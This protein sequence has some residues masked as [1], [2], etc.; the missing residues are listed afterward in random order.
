MDDVIRDKSS[1]TCIGSTMGNV[2]CD[3]GHTGRM[4]ILS[5]RIHFSGCSKRHDWH[6]PRTFK[7]RLFRSVRRF[8]AGSFMMLWRFSAVNVINSVPQATQMQFKTLWMMGRKSAEITGVA[9]V[10]WP[11]CPLQISGGEEH[12]EQSTPGVTVPSRGSKTVEI[13]PDVGVVS[14]VDGLDALS[15]SMD[16]T[17]FECIV[18]SFNR[19]ND[20]PFMSTRCMLRPVVMM[21]SDRMVNVSVYI[22]GRY[23]LE[24]YRDRLYIVIGRHTCCSKS[25]CRHCTSA[26]GLVAV[27]PKQ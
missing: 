18:S 10:I 4:S 13:N 14:R 16:M 17:D 1:E 5:T 9:S 3:M 22:F 25:Q 19:Q 8:C 26:W 21:K 24:I 20:N 23:T 7:E 27:R 6:G 2:S 12:V 15:P 11:V